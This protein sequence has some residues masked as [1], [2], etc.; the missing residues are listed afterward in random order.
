MTVPL[1]RAS[2]AVNVVHICV[3]W[4]QHCPEPWWQTVG[5]DPSM[6]IS[7]RSFLLKSQVVS[8]CLL[9]QMVR[10]RKSGVVVAVLRVWSF[11]SRERRGDLFVRPVKMPTGPS[12]SC[13]H[14]LS[15]CLHLRDF[16]LP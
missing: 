4:R 8:R 9:V 13:F 16:T 14:E 6:L 1:A 15:F 7:Y 3:T 12:A 5:L 11:S 2:N 10:V